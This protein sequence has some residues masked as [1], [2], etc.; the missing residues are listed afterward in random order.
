MER[1][2][3]VFDLVMNKKSE[4]TFQ[5]CLLLLYICQ[6][7]VELQQLGYIFRCNYSFRAIFYFLD[8]F[9]ISL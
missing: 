2:E 8:Y 3:K 4:K 5:E 9:C 1:L 7:K 6:I